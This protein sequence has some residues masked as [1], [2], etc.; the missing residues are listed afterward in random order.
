LVAQ[1]PGRPRPRHEFIEPGGGPKID[2]LGQHIGDVGLR[3]DAG[4]FARFDQ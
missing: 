4:E 1:A 2:E 3:I